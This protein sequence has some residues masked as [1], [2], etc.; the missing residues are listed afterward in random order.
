M[1]QVT[2]IKNNYNFTDYEFMIKIHH[3]LTNYNQYF[4][5]R[6]DD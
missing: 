6:I 1:I 3:T 5:N 2:Y 4:K